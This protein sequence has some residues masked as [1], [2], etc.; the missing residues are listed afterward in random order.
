MKRRTCIVVIIILSIVM[1]ALFL[2]GIGCSQ[3]AFS[4]GVSMNTYYRTQSNLYYLY[5]L[6]AFI[7]LGFVFIGFVLVL[8]V[9]PLKYGLNRSAHAGTT[10][11]N[12]TSPKSK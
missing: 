12:E 10:N 6:A 7:L 4:K 5:S 2:I 9:M 3:A 8:I 11:S 1:L